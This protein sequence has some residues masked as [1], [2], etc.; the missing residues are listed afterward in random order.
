M[1]ICSY[2]FNS[3]TYLSI[4]YVCYY[5][6][7]A[8]IYSCYCSFNFINL[9]INLPEFITEPVCENLDSLPL[10]MLILGYL[11]L[12]YTLVL[13]GKGLGFGLDALRFYII[14]LLIL[15]S[16]SS[17]VFMRLNVIYVKGFVE[18]VFVKRFCL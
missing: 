11:L 8:F 17:H 13:I 14:D 10:N 2:Y 3:D 6:Y 16:S 7:F 1:N 12:F 5:I 9:P 4:Y 15:M 18:D